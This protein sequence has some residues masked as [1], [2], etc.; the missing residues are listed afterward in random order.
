MLEMDRVF[1][2]R[3]FMNMERNG[4]FTDGELPLPPPEV[5][6][7]RTPNSRLLLFLSLIALVGTVSIPAF[8]LF[9]G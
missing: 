6:E 7:D 2:E 5:A 1:Y 3:R 8:A 4:Y 9:A